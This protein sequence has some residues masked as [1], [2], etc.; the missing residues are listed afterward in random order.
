[1][2]SYQI[3]QFLDSGDKILGPLNMRQFG[4]ALAGG[5]IGVMIYSVTQAIFPEIGNYA[6]IPAIPFAAIFAYLALGKYNGR[7]SEVYVLKYILYN[8][9]PR[10]MVYSRS[11]DYSD[12]N[13]KLAGLTY[14]SILERWNK[15]LSEKKAIESNKYLTF[16]SADTDARAEQVRQLGRNIDETVINSLEKVKQQETYINSQES[17][18]DVLQKQKNKRV[19]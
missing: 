19:K 18:L 14:N 16:E 3:P 11:P 4:Y 5:F 7:D 9:K 12:L 15:E 17:I 8:V 10:Q 13:K 2:T 1:M 6:I